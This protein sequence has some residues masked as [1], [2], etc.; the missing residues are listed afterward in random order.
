VARPRKKMRLGK[1]RMSKLSPIRTTKKAESLRRSSSSKRRLTISATP[2]P[3]W[4]NGRMRDS[5][6]L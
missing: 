2:L 6:C 4:L 5:R 1:T 3:P